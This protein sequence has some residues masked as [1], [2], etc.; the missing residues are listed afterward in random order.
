MK[1]REFLS[2]AMQHYDNPQCVN[3]EEFTNDLN[4]FIYLK[5]LFFRAKHNDDINERLIL[6]HIIT[7][8]NLFGLVTPDLL[9]FKIDKEYWNLLG[10][11]LYYLNL[12]PEQIPDLYMHKSNIILDKKLLNTLKSM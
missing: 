5:K 7:L 8:Y 10:T 2:L 12:L 6:N 4:K 1:D 3:V 11:F 9:F